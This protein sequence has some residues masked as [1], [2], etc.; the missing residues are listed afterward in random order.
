MA[1]DGLYGGVVEVQHR[2]MESHGNNYGVLRERERERERE[3][4]KRRETRIKNK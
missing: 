2:Q 1:R 4:V 3:S